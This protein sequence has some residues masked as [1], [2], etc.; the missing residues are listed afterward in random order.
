MAESD[1]AD[2]PNSLRNSCSGGLA[3]VPTRRAG[4]LTGKFPTLAESE[5][6]TEVTVTT[7]RTGRASAYA[8]MDAQA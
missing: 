3:T 5:L 1:L 6:A 8:P 7:T 2:T 4:W